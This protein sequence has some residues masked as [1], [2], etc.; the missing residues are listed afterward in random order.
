MPTPVLDDVK[1]RVYGLEAAVAERAV[2]LLDKLSRCTLRPYVLTSS[3]TDL[4]Q[5]AVTN[6]TQTDFAN[7]SEGP[8][9]VTKIRW[10]TA[11]S[12]GASAAGALFANVT[13]MIADTTAQFSFLKNATNLAVLASLRNNTTFLDRPYVLDQL[14]AFFVQLTEGDAAGTTDVYVAF[15]GETVAGDITAAE[16]REA[17]ALG[18]YPL[19]GRLTSPWDQV[20]LVSTLFGQHPVRLRGEAEDILYRLRLRVAGLREVLRAADYT[21]YGLSSTTS[22]LTQNAITSMTREDFRNEHPG[23]FAIQRSR[24]VT[25]TT[26]NATA[27]T[28]LFSNVSVD[29]SSVDERYKLTDQFALAPVLFS[30]ADN[31]WV[32]EHPHILGERGPIQVDLQEQDINGTTDVV[33][34]FL[35]EAVRHVSTADLRAAVALGLY[36]LMERVRN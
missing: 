16:V 23:P 19:A 35:G 12:L 36:P 6:M 9:V 25:V 17:I 22:N 29:M 21:A 10:F 2:I 27:I 33:V 30:R 4:A 3:V 31:S 28:A 5:A 8:F 34:T 14:A 15:H 11:A 24:I 32:Y 20:L 26:L 1:S 7:Q 13:A 18:V